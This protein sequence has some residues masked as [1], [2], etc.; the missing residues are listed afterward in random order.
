MW[1]SN[2]HR[3]ERDAVFRIH[4]L[5][6]LNTHCTFMHTGRCRVEELRQE[7]DIQSEINKREKNIRVSCREK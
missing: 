4:F 6:L 2:Q 3:L 1:P 7:K 5:S